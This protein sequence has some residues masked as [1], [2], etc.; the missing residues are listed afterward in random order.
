M[1]LKKGVNPEDLLSLGFSKIDKE[2]EYKQENYVASDNDYG[3]CIGYSRRGQFYEVYVNS[4]GLFS[5]Y[6][7]KP[8]GGGGSL[9]PFRVRI[10]LGAEE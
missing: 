1:K 10:I 5:V 6:A 9:V 3:I 4:A 2:E 7:T 8:D